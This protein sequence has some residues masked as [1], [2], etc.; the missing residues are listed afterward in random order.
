MSTPNDDHPTDEKLQRL[1]SISKL[2]YESAKIPTFAAVNQPITPSTPKVQDLSEQ[3]SPTKPAYSTPDLTSYHLARGG[4]S[5]KPADDEA[6]VNTA[7]LLL[8]Q[9][10]VMGV[11]DEFRTLDWLETR[12][13]F[14]LV[15]PITE[16]N[17]SNASAGTTTKKLME[18]R[19]DGYL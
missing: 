8:L 7:L 17:K 15:E 1:S 2:E 16:T 11:E 4:K 5:N 9:A 6:Y 10:V 13:P 12:L 14:K 3:D 18:A 19:V